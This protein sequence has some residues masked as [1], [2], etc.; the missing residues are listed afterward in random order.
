MIYE[1]RCGADPEHPVVEITHSIKEDHPVMA[2]EI[3]GE[4]MI[5]LFSNPLMAGRTPDPPGMIQAYLEHNWHRK[6]AG[7]PKFSPDKVKRPPE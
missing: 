3:C 5:R 7:M 6:R 1:F 4:K 2:C